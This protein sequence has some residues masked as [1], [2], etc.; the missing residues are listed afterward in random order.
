MTAE[1]DELG[2][3]TRYEY[4]DNLHLVSRRINPD[5][6]Q[7]R[8]RYDNARLLLTEIENERGEH[9]QLDY[10][11]NGLIREETGFDGRT[12]AYAYDLNGHLTE[13]TE[14][15]ED[16]SQ[17]VT[18]YQRDAAGRLLVKTLPDDQKIHYAY[19]ALG[20][21]VSVDDGQWPLAYEY[22]LQDRLITEH[23]GWATFRYQYDAL[24]QLSHCRLPDGSLLDYRY[25]HGG[26]LSAIDL[27]GQPL[28]AHQYLPGG[29]EQYRQ[30][31]ALLSHYHYD[32]QGRLQAHR[33]SQQ[34]RSVYQRRYAYDANGN[35][36]AI[37]DSRKG[38]KHFHYD[39]L[40][41]LIAVRGDLPE[42]FAHD[43]AGNLLS[44]TGQEGARLAN[45]KGNR[46][47]MQGD[48]HYDYD[49]YGNL[50]RERRGASQRLVTEYRYD[51]QHRL[52]AAT[53]P[54]GR[55]AEYRYDAFGRRIAK[56]IDGQTT[57]FL[58]QGERLIAESGQNHY[59]SYVYEPGTFR[60][61]AMLLGEGRA[62]EPYY[63][64]LDHLGTPQELTSTAGSIVWSAKYRAYG[65]VAKLEVA[66]LENPLRFQ[67][68][69][70]D[71]ETGLHYNR[72]RY[73]NPNTGRFLTPDPIKLAGGLNNY[74]YVPNP[75]GWVDPLGLNNCPGQDLC[76][77]NL[78]S[79]LSKDISYVND[80]E[81]QPASPESKYK[82]LYRGDTRSQDIIFEDGFKSKGDSNDLQL[83][84][85]DNNEPPSN[86]IS[87][88][89]SPE[90]GIDFGTAYRTKPGYLYTLR[91]LKG[92]DV[93]NEKGLKVPFPDEKE[94]AVPK[95]VKREDILG[96]TP[97]KADG[98]YKGYSIP[99]PRRI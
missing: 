19:D 59:R 68:Q 80:G 39:P 71:Q 74:Q 5:G 87:T 69:Y 50:T 56:I 23:Q 47:L 83:H 43:P 66:E 91:L 46:L 53:L 92:I 44:Q 52:I 13:K 86:F 99:N 4:A 78:N 17:L 26:L 60:P 48:S 11:P 76:N 97:L 77:P 61:L 67:G 40:D 32:E 27:N 85:Y 81:P 98:S 31:G 65:N 29:R 73:Y 49:A 70:F 96:V 7:L 84:V 89:T 75:T 93:N 21:L 25:R 58:W 54:D 35:L 22:D 18:C 62:A 57:E 14:F 30:Q 9:Y 8:Y 3:V 51:S 37:E 36:A 41:R 28:T 16:G 10:Y 79:S 64:Q 82:Y 63:Y 33:I 20:R 42:S 24:G 2:R 38:N 6:S 34:E 72:H 15:G 55:I 45:V 90:V 94:I 88:S 95:E 1:R 12:T